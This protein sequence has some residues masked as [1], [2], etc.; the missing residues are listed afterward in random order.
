MMLN[1]FFA[2]LYPPKISLCSLAGFVLWFD[3]IESVRQGY[4][5]WWWCV[6]FPCSLK[7]DVSNKISQKMISLIKSTAEV[8][9]RPLGSDS[10]CFVREKCWHSITP[11]RLV[12][13]LDKP[14]V[15]CSISQWNKM[16]PCESL[17]MLH[18]LC[19]SHYSL[20]SQSLCKSVS[21][22]MYTQALFSEQPSEMLV[23]LNCYMK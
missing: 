7:A 18:S 21:V 11:P 17:Q 8:C 20:V 23:L 19:V 1:R 22:L 13:L 9:E 10:F 16:P 5:W 14:D 12:H 6:A 4:C 2:G 15:F 3:V